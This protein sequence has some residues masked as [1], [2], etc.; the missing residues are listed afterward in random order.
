MEIVQF[1]GRTSAFLEPAPGAASFNLLKM[2]REGLLAELR[3]AIHAAR[4]KEGIVRREGLRI[5]TDAHVVNAS[6]EVIPF[7]G[8]GNE[9]YFLVLFH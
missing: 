7:I 1:R 2:A 8:G 9:R 5:K 6:V 3:T 4:K